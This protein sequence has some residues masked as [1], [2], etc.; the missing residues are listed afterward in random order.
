MRFSNR[1]ARKV[2]ALAVVLV[3]LA[4]TDSTAVAQSCGTRCIPWCG[5][6]SPHDICQS[7]FGG[8]CG[9]GATCTYDLLECGPLQGT[10]RCW[11]APEE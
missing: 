1:L 8:S 7:L 4:T 6:N 9:L 5:G 10:L 2:M 11:G 3:G